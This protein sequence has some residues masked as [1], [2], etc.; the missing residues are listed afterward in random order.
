MSS[1]LA[2]RGSHFR[3]DACL[4]PRLE[5]LL[6][7]ADMVSLHVPE[8]LTTELLVEAAEIDA[9]KPGGVLI[10]TSRGPGSDALTLA[11]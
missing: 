4:V 9:I 5:A 3:C 1:G 7:Q 8:T 2:H 10:N 11:A 6:S